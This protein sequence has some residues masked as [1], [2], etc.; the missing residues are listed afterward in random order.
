MSIVSRKRMQ[1]KMQV[2]QKKAIIKKN[3]K[4]NIKKVKQLRLVKLVMV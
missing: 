3:L 2:K 1:V 4:V